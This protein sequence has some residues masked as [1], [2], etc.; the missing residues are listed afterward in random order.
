[1]GGREGISGRSSGAL[2]VVMF[3]GESTHPRR[4]RA[5]GRDCAGTLQIRLQT[6]RATAQTGGVARR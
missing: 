1:M 4:T 2:L 5:S 6:A 3:S